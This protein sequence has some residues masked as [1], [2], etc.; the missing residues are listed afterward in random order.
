MSARRLAAGAL[1]LV[2]L[3]PGGCSPA[4]AGGGSATPR[5]AATPPARP[6]TV[7]VWATESLRLPFERLA[8]RYEQE[9]PGAVVELHCAGGAEL[10][11]QRNAGGRCDVLAIGDSSLMSRFAAAAFLA[12]GT[13]AELARNRIAIAVAAGNP[14]RVQGLADLLRPGLK[15]AFGRRSSS[16]GRYT[17]W[18]LSAAGHDVTVSPAVEAD[19][20]E[21][22]LA[23]VQDG[24]ADAGVVYQTTLRGQP[25]VERIDVPAPQNQPVLYSIAVDRQAREPEG[26]AAFCALACG[27]AGQALLAEAGFL[28]I[29]AK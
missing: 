10:L 20:A 11:A 1:A 29:G 14:Q 12:S 27:A 28:P 5:A 22:V 19:T 7:V 23:A 13:A 24:R 4:D 26:A 6:H 15:L 18:A 16:I 3:L 25:G 9:A 21:Q 2:L 8:R 17:R